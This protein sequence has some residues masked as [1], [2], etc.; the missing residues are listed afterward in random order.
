MGGCALRRPS[1]H[2][3]KACAAAGHC[4]GGTCAGR[5]LWCWRLFLR[6]P[7]LGPGARH[8]FYVSSRCALPES[9]L[10]LHCCKRL[11][12]VAVECPDLPC[13]NL[14]HDLC[15]QQKSRDA[16]SPLRSDV[17]I[18]NGVVLFESCL[19]SESECVCVV[20]LCESTIRYQAI[21]VQ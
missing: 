12:K 15:S 7:W 17:L 4:H 20:R 5:R 19:A 21:S 14:K 6:G 1:R 10:L 16:T 2:Q 18:L 11:S 3:C 13:S 8:A 9:S